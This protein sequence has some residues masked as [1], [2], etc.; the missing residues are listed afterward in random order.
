MRL[1]DFRYKQVAGAVNRTDK[2]NIWRMIFEL[3]A[4]LTHQYIDVP[5]IRIPFPVSDPI[6]QLVPDITSPA[7]SISVNSKL[8]SPADIDSVAPSGASSSRLFR[9]RVQSL[10]NRLLPLSFCRS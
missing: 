1:S 8:N 7:L 5:V 3:S 9:S 10:K 4:D 6:H 2:C